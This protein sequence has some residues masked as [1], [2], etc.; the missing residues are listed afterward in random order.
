[1]S[2]IHRKIRGGN[3]CRGM[4]V[5]PQRQYN[6]LLSRSAPQTTQKQKNIGIGIVVV[7]Q[8][9]WYLVGCVVHTQ[10]SR[11]EATCSQS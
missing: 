6:A 5:V 7:M 2:K 9:V 8:D 1:M 11:K 10:G 4:G 3:L